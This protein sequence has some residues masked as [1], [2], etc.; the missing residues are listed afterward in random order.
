ME[1]LGRLTPTGKDLKARLEGAELEG[2]GEF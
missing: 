1:E 2:E